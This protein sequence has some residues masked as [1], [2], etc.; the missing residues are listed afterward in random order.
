MSTPTPV[1]EAKGGK[2]SHHHRAPRHRR[3]N[4]ETLSSG[5]GVNEISLILSWSHKLSLPLVIMYNWVLS[6]RRYLFKKIF[7]FHERSENEAE[8]RRRNEIYNK[9]KLFR[10]SGARRIN[11]N[12]MMVV[13]GMAGGAR[14]FEIFY[15]L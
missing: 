6:V 12:D 11:E 15:E 9:I 14:I 4:N 3:Q 1:G 8:R 13:C 2:T 5:F 7:L 10:F